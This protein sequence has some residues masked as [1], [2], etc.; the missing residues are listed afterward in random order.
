MIPVVQPKT[1][2]MGQPGERDNTGFLAGGR[3]CGLHVCT[4]SALLCLLHV[5]LSFVQISRHQTVFRTNEAQKLRYSTCRL[6]RCLIS[7]S[8]DRPSYSYRGC[9]LIT[10]ATGLS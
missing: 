8:Q 9:V 6:Q 7:I 3:G 5:T 4:C 2:K 1:C 10:K